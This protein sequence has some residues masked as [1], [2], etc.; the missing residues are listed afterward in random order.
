[1]VAFVKG[2]FSFPSVA[3]HYF[4]FFIFCSILWLLFVAVFPRGCREFAVSFALK[5]RSARLSSALVSHVT[6][7]LFDDH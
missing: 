2:A 3:F 7:T 1:M 5:L 4:P 6:K